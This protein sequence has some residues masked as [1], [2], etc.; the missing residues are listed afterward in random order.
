MFTLLLVATS[1]QVLNGCRNVF[2]DVGANTGEHIESVYN[3]TYARGALKETFTRYFGP[4]TERR[5][6]TCAVGIEPN[7]HQTQSLMSLQRRHEIS[8]LRTT[9]LTEVAATDA[10]SNAQ[11]FFV[12]NLTSSGRRHNEWGSTLFDYGAIQINGRASRVRVR[13]LD[14][15]SWIQHN[16][17]ER[18]IPVS[19]P[20]Q[21]KAAV[22][23]KMDVEGAEF[24][25]L[26]RLL[27]TGVL[28]SLNAL[29]VEFHDERVPG[30]V[31]LLKKTGAPFNFKAN[32][33]YM[34]RAAQRTP[35]C[36][37][38]LNHISPSQSDSR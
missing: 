18:D 9:M 8:G 12:D 6:T 25:L 22:I 34:L 13:G 20:S 38:M 10:E 21:R 37:V 36:N 30:F 11:T 29:F 14:L 31:P 7:P 33:E 5:Q 26:P 27:V 2:I 32:F 4:D 24:L 19:P 16:V 35:G 23:V 1:E 15:A 17:L 28:C 3:D